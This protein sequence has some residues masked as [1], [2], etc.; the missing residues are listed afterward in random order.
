[1]G[2]ALPIKTDR[3]WRLEGSALAGAVGA[4]C[5]TLENSDGTRR[6][7][8]TSALRHYEGRAVL[9][10]EA[11]YY[12]N[13]DVVYES[14]IYNVSRSACDTAKADIAGRQ[15]PKPIFVTTG[16]DWRARR[17]AKKADKYCEGQMSQRQG[18]YANCWELMT[19]VFHDS[20]KLGNG[21]AKVTP[22]VNRKKILVERV[23]PW[24]LFVD[25]R[26]ARYGAPQN[27]FHRYSMETDIA[28][29]T[30]VEFGE[31]GEP[32]DNPENMEAY[33]GILSA[34]KPRSDSTKI[35]EAVIVNEA[36]RLPLGDKIPG[37]HVICVEGAI[38]F[39]EEWTEPEFPFVMLSWENDTVGFWA[40]GLIEAHQ[41]QHV[42]LNESAMA[43]AKRMQICSTKRVYYDPDAVEPEHLSRGGESE[44]QIPVKD[45]TRIPVET[46]TVPATQEEFAWV[47]QNID[48]YFQFSGVSQQSAQATKS[49]GLTAAVAI[50]AENDL[51]SQRFMPK[52]RAYEEAFATLG[53]LIISATRRIAKENRGSFPVKWPGKRFLMEYDWKD[54]SLAED[55]YEIRVATISALWR[56]PAMQLQVAQDLHQ[57]GI[58]NR[59]TFLQMAQLPD[60][61][62]LMNRETAEREFLEELFDRYLDSMDDSELEE[63]GGYEAPEPFI[64]NK[65]AAMW[66]AVSTYWEARRDKA[67]LYCLS[68][69]ERWISQLDK[70]IA[71]APQQMGSPEAPG[72]IMGAQ[73]PAMP[74][75][76]GMQPGAPLAA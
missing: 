4:I 7:R 21:I 16:G 23:F 74:T 56:D 1:M 13:I 43:L 30:F 14:P 15:K 22:D 53:R 67:P 29:E 34:Q 6:T 9:L 11:S 32:L 25:P 35:I 2:T 46:S 18:R 42:I 31:D 75:A 39:E 40:T 47:G 66:L 51:G 68:L 36:W 60:L 28:L 52:A 61:E 20:A 33:R 59:E 54:V 3:W 58:I 37:K 71:P 64:T 24:E 73:G 45:L 65:P 49:P 44:I 57:G 41:V 69:L 38:L 5:Y 70:L 63:A 62:G 8:Y 55:M 19:E 76:P 12:C 72:A 50:E 27:L 48:R 17:K 26:E 10:D